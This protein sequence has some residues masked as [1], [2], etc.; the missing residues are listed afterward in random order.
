[1]FDLHRKSTVIVCGMLLIS[2][3]LYG[4][5][6]LI[7]GKPADIGL[8][9]I[10]NLA[11]LPIY[12]LFVTLMIEGVLREREKEALRQKMNMVIGVFFSEVGTHLL[13]D[14]S[15]FL[16]DKAGLQKQVRITSEWTDRDFSE[17]ARYLETAGLRIDIRSSSVTCL[18][19]FL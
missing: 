1:M 13:R 7:F 11:F 3:V 19:E 4:I 6:Y 15:F 8:G 17:L 10:G 2:V 14:G 9:F 16:S 12:V 5:D 18:K